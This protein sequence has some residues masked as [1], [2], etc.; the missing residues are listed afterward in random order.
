MESLFF[1]GSARKQNKMSNRGDE[2]RIV[3]GKHIGNTGW[4]NLDGDETPCYF[5]VMLDGFYKH[6]DGRTRNKTTSVMKEHVGSKDL[7]LPGSRAEAIMQQHS[8]IEQMMVKLARQLAK[9]ELN[10]RSNSIQ[11]I[12]AKKLQDA[13][14]R[15]TAM[16]S[17][18]TYK[19]VRCNPRSDSGSPDAV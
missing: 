9:C 15:Q 1:C 7:Q 11:Q 18:A 19:R 13:T 2:I 8:D 16:G 10:P 17:K 4:F 14:A 5:P 3:G 6:P 12:F